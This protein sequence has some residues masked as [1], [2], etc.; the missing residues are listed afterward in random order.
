MQKVIYVSATP[1]DKEISLSQNNVIE[2][3]VRPTYLVDPIIVVKPKD[4]QVEDL[5]EEIINQRQNNTRTFVTVLTIKMAENLTEYLKERKIKVAYIHK[6]IK[7]LERL[8]LINDLRRGEYECLVGIN[9]LREGLD[10]PEVALVCIFDADIPG[11]PRDER[12]LIQIIGR[13]ARN[14]HG[15]VVMYANHVTEQMQ[16]AIDETKRRRT[17]Q[18]EYNKLHNKTPKT[19]V[20]PLTFVQP[21]KLKAKSN[22][23][24]KCC[25]NQTINQRNEESSS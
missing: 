19:V 20:K 1:R 5:I 4:N 9:L 17:V 16:K 11:L 25:I 7:A 18:M 6:D 3:L 23:E 14:E 21:I 8:L 2:Q 22:A 24:K 15:R 10:V 12:S 13:A